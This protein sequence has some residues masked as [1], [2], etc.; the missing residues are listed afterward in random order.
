MYRPHEAWAIV[1]PLFLPGYLAVL[2][3]GASATTQTRDACGD[4]VMLAAVDAGFVTEAGGSAK[5]DGTVAPGA[6]YNYS[7]G[8]EVHYAGGFLFSGLAAMDRKNYF[9]F[10]LSAVTELIASAELLLYAGPDTPPPFPGGTHGYESLDPTETYG[11]AATASPDIALSEIALLKA[12]NLIGPTA[13]DA[14][15]DPTIPAA[16]GLYSKLAAG[17]V[18]LA[19]KT[20]SPADDG[21][22]V[23]LPFTPDGVAYLNSFLGSTVVL[24]GKTPTAVPPDSPQLVFGFTGPDIAGGG[25]LIPTLVISLVPEVSGVWFMCL[26]A[27]AVWGARR[28]LRR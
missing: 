9:V 13:F 7:A 25:P 21:T 8:R 19:F 20:M 18:P 24:G 2:L 10:D 12:A 23:S 26:A 22:T 17:L 3:V 11:I 4:V 28:W 16:I 5:G 1:H 15:S 14:P 27:G 6:T